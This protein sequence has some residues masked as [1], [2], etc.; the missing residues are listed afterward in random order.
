MS[1][2]DLDLHSRDPCALGYPADAKLLT[3]INLSVNLISIFKVRLK[4][5]QHNS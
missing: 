3:L 2:F 1:V 5:T 4:N